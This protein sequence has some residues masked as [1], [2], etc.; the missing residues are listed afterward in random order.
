MATRL[1]NL[2]T[3]HLPGISESD[4]SATSS[5][6]RG[7]QMAAF[8]RQKTAGRYP[9]CHVWDFWH[10]RQDRKPKARSESPPDSDSSAATGPSYEDR[11][12]NLHTVSDIKQFW[13]LFNNFDVTTLPLRDSV[14]LFHHGVKPVWEDPRNVRGG[15]WTFRVP[16]EKAPQFWKETCVMAIGDELQRAVETDRTTFR[17]DICGIS[18]SVR[19]T[20]TLVTIWNRDGDHEDGIQNILKTVLNGL[21]P[22]LIP[23]ESAYYYKKHSEHAGFTGVVSAAS[24][25]ATTTSEKEN[26]IDAKMTDA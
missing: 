16:K 21:S 3:S 22:E 14:H 18:L 15:S 23:K 5:P 20:S 9:L 19:F 10:D 7:K 11:L 13:E 2:L 17:D 8:I 6:S 4:A 1:P 25:P 26:P 12:V 24:G